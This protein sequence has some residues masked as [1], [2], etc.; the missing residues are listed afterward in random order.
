MYVK[1]TC[2]RSSALINAM[3][4]HTARTVSS[5][6]AFT[7]C[8]VASNCAPTTGFDFNFKQEIHIKLQLPSTPGDVSNIPLPFVL[9]SLKLQ[10]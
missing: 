8:Q 5:A 9:C 10:V 1:I 2:V 3:L 4:R 6:T 7:E